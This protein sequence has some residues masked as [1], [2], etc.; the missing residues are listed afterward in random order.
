MDL[1]S[2][3]KETLH[4]P[5]STVAK[6]GEVD[7]N[8]PGSFPADDTQ[9][10]EDQQNP[11]FV[12]DSGSKHN[13]LHKRNDPRGWPEEGVTGAG[14]KHTDSGVGLSQER[15]TSPSKHSNEYTI[16]GTYLQ[17]DFPHK[18]N[19]TTESV[20]QRDVPVFG[21]SAGLS[22]RDTET[23]EPSREAHSTSGTAAVAPVSQ[24]HDT[25]DKKAT[26]DPSDIIQEHPY[27]GD[28]PRGAGTYNTVTGHGS[29]EDQ[30]KR[31]H[32]LYEQE[33]HATATSGAQ[34]SI[35][36]DI[37][38][39]DKD[40]KDS[41]AAGGISTGPT[42][43]SSQYTQAA[44]VTGEHPSTVRDITG[45]ENK[46]QDSSFA[47]GG[48]PP[49]SGQT[50]TQQT[51][52]PLSGEHPSTARD[53]ADTD[54][55]QDEQ[56][57]YAAKEGAIGGTAAAGAAAAAAWKMHDKP[58][59]DEAT[60]RAEEA[61]R[62]EQSGEH[63]EKRTLGGLFHH[64]SKDSDEKEKVKEEKHKEEK[65]EKK[66]EKKP[67]L[68][69]LFHRG[70][71]DKSDEQKDDKVKDREEKKDDDSH[72]T[73]AYTAAGAGAGAAGAGAYIA[74]KNRD[75]DKEKLAP[76]EHY[77][78]E[79]KNETE[80]PRNVVH[81]GTSSGIRSEPVTES[82]DDQ[83]PAKHYNQDES[84]HHDK[85]AL[86]AAG[87]TGLGA[88]ALSSRD[89]D[90][91]I[92][93]NERTDN[94]ATNKPAEQRLEGL[95]QDS[96]PEV[97]ESANHGQYNVLDSGTPSGFPDTTTTA[98]TGISTQPQGP[99]PH[100]TE[101][102]NHGEYNVLASGTPSGIRIEADEHTKR[103]AEPTIPESTEEKHD[104]SKWAA[105]GLGAAGV[106]AG[107]AAL[108]SR[109]PEDDKKET[110]KL[111]PIEQEQIKQYEIEE[112]K[113][114]SAPVVGATASRPDKV[115]HKC[116]KCGEEN[117]ISNYFASDGSRKI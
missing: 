104:K 45:G 99:T 28:L 77:E 24:E 70:D 97:T 113:P 92:V 71:K 111:E 87:A 61:K 17:Q 98:S 36:R 43:S 90:E 30:P 108:S 115:I 96:T 80:A 116:N 93:D 86:A 62:N 112:A 52:Q 37:T 101:S 3:I 33:T 6:H 110:D 50:H 89:R 27:W 23:A 79:A 42:E 25:A 68:G 10:L 2:R 53:I 46:L 18:D 100:V 48:V 11:G 81:T 47:A 57:S 41:F 59:D 109:D 34:P 13:K 65:H 15:E 21:G 91:K 83:V 74:S 58:Q 54:R 44:P 117:D 84:S 32:E 22:T 40:A 73:L 75:E 60:R 1:G 35:T 88:A 4:S 76:T 38:S 9:P 56:R 102:A 20:P 103:S 55:P 114:N 106:G 5:E 14:H 29:E 19:N 67:L 82:I 16:S 95:P 26:R 7:Q 105:A 78:R 8:T 66:H 94:L 39:D 64:K 107:A 31:Q 12:P 72:N 85:T 51:Q 49:I 63:K 69:G